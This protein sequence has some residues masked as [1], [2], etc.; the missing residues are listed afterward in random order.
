[1]KNA[2]ALERL[3]VEFKGKV[4]VLQ[5]PVP[6]LRDLKKLATEVIREESEKTPVARKVHASFSRFQAMLSPWDHV[7]EGAYHQFITA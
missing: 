7:A 3:K 4:E 6:V 5:F 1:V 2:M